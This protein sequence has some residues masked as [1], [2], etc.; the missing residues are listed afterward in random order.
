MNTDHEQHIIGVDLDTGI[1]VLEKHKNF[2]EEDAVVI[3]FR[4][5]PL[6]G[7]KIQKEE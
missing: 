1:L 5:C 4:Y 6:C 3:Y 2:L 7:E